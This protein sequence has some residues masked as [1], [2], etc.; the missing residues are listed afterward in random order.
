[1][2]N[3]QKS[4]QFHSVSNDQN[5]QKHTIH[6]NDGIVNPYFLKPHFW[7]MKLKIERGTNNS[8]NTN[9]HTQSERMDRSFL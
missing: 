7:C 8:T 5:L 3:D 2:M 6:F 1:M 4:K 9:T